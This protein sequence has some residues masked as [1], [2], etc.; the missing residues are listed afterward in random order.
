MNYNAYDVAVM[1]YPLF[2]KELNEEYLQKELFEQPFD[3]DYQ[4]PIYIHIPFCDS[5]CDFCIYNRR[6]A[7]KNIE[8]IELYVQALIKEINLYASNP[9]IAKLQIGSVFIG[10][11]TPTVLSNEQL[12]KI[13]TALKSAFK[14][15]D[16]EITVECNAKNADYSKLKMLKDL[17]VTRISTGVQTFDNETRKKLNLQNKSEYV[18]EW[19]EKVRA[20]CFDDISMDLI[21]GFPNTDVD[22]FL[23][24]IEKAVE[25]KLGHLSIYKLTVFAYTKLYHDI[26]NN[27]FMKLPTHEQ[28]YQMFLESHAYLVKSGYTVQSTQ[29]YSRKD[30]TVKFWD[31]TYD[32]YGDN[33]SFGTSSFG[34]INGCCYQNS[35]NIKKYI[36]QLDKTK[37]PIERISPRITYEQR[38]ERALII[39]FR[40]GIV[41][42][43]LFSDNFHVEIEDV[44]SDQINTHL[45]QGYIFETEDAYHLTAKGLFY[46]G[47]VSADYMIS[48]FHRVSPL[49]K[50]MCIGLHQMP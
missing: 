8:L 5:L 23:K 17:G 32:G 30:K 9:Y 40:K 28:L 13:I 38:K 29:E 20:L 12:Y 21:Y 36:D 24:D 50:K 42:K 11:G 2:N 46:Q 45:E 35:T 31:L 34:Y 6:L 25:M 7:P 49:K 44:F 15:N 43:K 33:L 48:I 41:S 1:N 26:L 19:F 4:V 27:S 39:G 16:L 3:E 37:M 47:K 14:I 22:F 18:K 10:G